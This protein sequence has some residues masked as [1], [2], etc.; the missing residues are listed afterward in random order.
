MGISN[1][2]L[3]VTNA[4]WGD[5]VNPLADALVKDGKR[6]WVDVDVCPLSTLELPNDARQRAVLREFADWDDVKDTRPLRVIAANPYAPE[7]LEQFQ[8]LVNALKLRNERLKYAA[9]DDDTA[10]SFSEIVRFVGI[11]QVTPREILTPM[12]PGSSVELAKLI[13]GE[14]EANE[15]CIVLEEIEEVGGVAKRLLAANQRVVRMPIFGRTKNNPDSL[16]LSDVPNFILVNDPYALSVAVQGLRRLAADL[17]E[18]VWVGNSALL[19][20]MVKRDAPGSTWLEV[21][22]LRHDVILEKVSKY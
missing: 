11:D 12:A 15:L 20:A 10:L 18:I 2:N 19:Q 3:I 7:A 1:A 8:P 5:V 17:S 13:S 21:P 16:K 4:T 9:L 14:A 6:Y 22:D